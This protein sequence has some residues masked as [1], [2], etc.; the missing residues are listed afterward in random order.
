[1]EAGLG[2]PLPL[3]RDT[4]QGHEHCPWARAWP[5]GAAGHSGEPLGT[6]GAVH[7]PN[8]GM[9]LSETGTEQNVIENMAAQQD[10]ARDAMGQC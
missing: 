6:R 8:M 3:H 2:L 7:T 4:T 1:M 5:A 10:R 9:N